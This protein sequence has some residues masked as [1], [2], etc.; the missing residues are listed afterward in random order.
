MIYQLVN[1]RTEILGIATSHIA[2]FFATSI[3]MF[4]HCP[5]LC[6]VSI[7]LI[8]VKIGI[9]LSYLKKHSG[10][11]PRPPKKPPPPIADLWL[12]A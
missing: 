6:H 3:I 11:A 4:L 2:H 9:K 8:F 10:S 1:K 7:V 12:R 5:F